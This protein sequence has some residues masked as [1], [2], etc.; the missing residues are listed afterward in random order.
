MI[1][2]RACFAVVG[3]LAVLVLY[4]TSLSPVA[5]AA[6]L[7]WSDEFNGSAVDPGNWTFE[8]GGGGWGNK[9]LEYYTNGAN[10]SVAGGSLTIEARSERV[11]ANKYTSSRLKTQGKREFKFGHIEGIL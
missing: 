10:A 5:R 2:R 3:I 6:T 8:T 9:E 7:V 1:L 4:D 11:R